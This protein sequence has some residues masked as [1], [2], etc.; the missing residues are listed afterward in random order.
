MWPQPPPCPD[1]SK[2]CLGEDQRI[3]VDGGR[4]ARY[5]QEQGIR[6]FRQHDG[7]AAVVMSS[8]GI[9]VMFLGTMGTLPTLY[10][11]ANAP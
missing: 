4:M 7:R 10:S 2:V 3:L 11:G 5:A 1:A 8:G 9:S 6:L